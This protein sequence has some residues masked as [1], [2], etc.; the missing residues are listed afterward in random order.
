MHAVQKCAILCWT[1]LQ[2]GCATSL[3]HTLTP[4]ECRRGLQC[5]GSLIGRSHVVTAAHCVYDI[6]ES[7][8]YVDSLDFKPGADGGAAPYGTLRWKTARVLSQFTSQV[9]G[10]CG[11]AYAL[12][13]PHTVTNGI[14]GRLQLLHACACRTAPKIGRNQCQAALTVKACEAQGGASQTSYTPTAMNYDFALVTLEDEAPAATGTLGLYQ[15]PSSG[16]ASV[17]LTTA[18][19]AHC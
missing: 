10:I 14:T 12:Q 4:L 3:G 9:S 19:A 13:E 1:C 5:S 8:Q 18:G 15:P 16:S 11:P 7:H 6:N 2:Q 17:S